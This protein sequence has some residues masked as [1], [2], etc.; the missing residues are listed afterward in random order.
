MTEY[1]RPSLLDLRTHQ[2]QPFDSGEPVLDDWL[3]RYTGQNRRGDTAA[4]WA[5]VD[6]NEIVVAYA[7]LS[8]TGVDASSAPRRLGKGAPDPIPA[9]L[10]GR[11]AVDHRHTRRGLGTALVVH[12]LATAVEL[13]EQAA[14]R[15]V[16]VTA[17]QNAARTWWLRLGFEP[18]DPA[19][20][21]ELQL[22]LLTVDIG[23][24]LDQLR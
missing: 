8:M 19:D 3:K 20:P 13:N 18:F 16:V 6:G 2:R 12:V 21:E 9:L 23:A 15:A 22:Y 5:I 17:L 11:L 10:L 24:T 4:T 7:S 1:R 14:C